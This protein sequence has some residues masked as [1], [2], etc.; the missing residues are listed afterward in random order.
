[1]GRRY[2]L[3]DDSDLPI[4]QSK[5]LRLGCKCLDWTADKKGRGSECRL[6]NES[7]R[8]K[9]LPDSKVAWVA[10][11]PAPQRRDII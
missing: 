7:A 5:C 3:D 4:C 8:T 10:Y 2:F 6:N 9:A 1:M 11:V